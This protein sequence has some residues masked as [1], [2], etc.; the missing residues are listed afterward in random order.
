[1]RRLLAFVWR[2]AVV[3]GLSFAGVTCKKAS[4]DASNPLGTSLIFDNASPDARE[5]LATPVDFRITDENFAQWEQAQ[6]YL[7]Q[8]PRSAIASGPGPG[9]SAIDRAVARLESSPR[10]RTAIERTGLSVK[11]F[12]LETVALAQ[13]TEASQGGKSTNR[14]AL[15]G[16]NSRFVQQYQSRVLRARA[17]DNMR[18][19]PADAFGVRSAMGSSESSE[20]NMQRDADHAQMQTAHDSE[21]LEHRSLRQADSMLDRYNGQRPRPARDT[22][23]SLHRPTR[24]TIPAPR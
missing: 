2:C 19:P 17:M 11:D 18:G 15:L 23:D 16:E 24:D 6:E 5:A 21:A 10:A 7:D 13:A 20:M 8:L 4:R 22:L 3:A 1:M 14:T 12:V 9:G